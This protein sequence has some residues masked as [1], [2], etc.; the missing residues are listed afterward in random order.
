MHPVGRRRWTGL[1]KRNQGMRVEVHVSIS[2]LLPAMDW[3]WCWCSYM[4]LRRGGEEARCE[5][6]AAARCRGGGR[7]PGKRRQGEARGMLDLFPRGGWAGRGVFRVHGMGLF[8]VARL[9]YMG[10][11]RL[12]VDKL[13]CRSITLTCRVVL[14]CRHPG[15][16]R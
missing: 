12:V 4:G 10:L 6:A 14:C 15:C 11:S 9:T 5:A 13:S 8:L 2:Y 3:Y 1:G 16:D 7:R